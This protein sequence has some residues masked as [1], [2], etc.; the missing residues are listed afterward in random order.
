MVE[1]LVIKPLK[2]LRNTRTKTVE[3]C[4][5]IDWSFWQFGN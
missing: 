2:D 4:Y 3:K 5:Q 1:G